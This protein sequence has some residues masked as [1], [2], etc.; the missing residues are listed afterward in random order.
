MH[1][2]WKV[3]GADPEQS[4]GGA[5]LHGFGEAFQCFKAQGHSMKETV[6]LWLYV[7]KTPTAVCCSAAY[8]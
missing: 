2:L 6:F 1:A 3:Y 8:T 4:T 7:L 5:S